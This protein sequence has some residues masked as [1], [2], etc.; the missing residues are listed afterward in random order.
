MPTVASDLSSSQRSFLLHLQALA[1]RYFLDNQ[2]DDGL[3]L[4]RQRNFGPPRAGGWSSTAATGMGFIALALASADP[5][6]LLPRS[7]AIGRLGHG[8]RTALERLPQTHGILPHF[9]DARG[10]TVGFDARSTID[11]AWLIAGGLW[12]A[13][14]LRDPGLVQLADRLFERV[15]W[16]HWTT[17]DG[18]IRHGDD[19]QGRALPCAWD[20]LNGET[21]FLYVLAAGADRAWPAARWSGLRPFFGTTAGLRFPSADLGLFVFQYGLD[22]LDLELWREP[23]GLDLASTAA[24]ATAANFRCCRAAADR[25]ETYR[26]YWG[27]SAGDGPGDTLTDEDCYRC[28]APGGPLD[29]TA[30]LTATLASVRHRPALVLDNLLQARDETRLTALGRYG[31]SNINLDRGWVGRDMVG[32][33]AGAAVLALDNVLAE[34][35]VRKV[36][37]ELP[38][39]E[40]GLRRLGFR[41]AVALPLAS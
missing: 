4:D 38:C 5:F 16:K 12:S 41:E 1:L 28:Y 27:L 11:S 9:T 31:F 20:R 25:F 24:T 37:H 36:F 10:A 29:G 13:A 19:R 7:E 26:Y 14:F 39:V 32:I 3:F 15:D 22:L 23:R 21:V 35:R 33:D 40:R 17:S 34:D 8:L 18:L 30:H 6:R 2:T